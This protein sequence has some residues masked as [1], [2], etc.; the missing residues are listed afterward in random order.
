MD[1]GYFQTW[2]C[3]GKLYS[4]CRHSS[5]SWPC[6]LPY[7]TYEFYHRRKEPRSKLL[8]CFQSKTRQRFFGRFRQSFIQYH[9]SHP[10]KSVGEALRCVSFQNEGS[11]SNRWR[12]SWSR[13]RC[14]V[15]RTSRKA[16][17]YP[18]AYEQSGF[19]QVESSIP[20]SVY[21][22]KIRCWN[23]SHLYRSGNGNFLCNCY[24]RWNRCGYVRIPNIQASLLLGW[25]YTSKRSK[26][27]KEENHS[28]QPCRGIYQTF[29]G[30]VRIGCY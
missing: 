8:N 1:S 26:R 30:S 18:W 4:S 28:H 15:S 20:H 16:S 19:V 27:G 21:R 24:N 2:P 13:W 14:N 29:I 5:A 25:A 6:S 10:R 12:N 7:E 22:R 23:W 11:E 17:Y 9:R 3:F